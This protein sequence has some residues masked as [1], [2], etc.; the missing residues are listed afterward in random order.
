MNSNPV[1]CCRFL[2]KTDVV[3]DARVQD[4]NGSIEKTLTLKFGIV[5]KFEACWNLQ[6]VIIKSAGGAASQA[7]TQL[8]NSNKQPVDK[9]SKQPAPQLA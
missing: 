5:G 2:Y 8:A 3:V 4:D 7:E 9:L 6:A 1:C